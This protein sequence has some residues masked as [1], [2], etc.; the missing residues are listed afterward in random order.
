MNSAKLKLPLEFPEE[1]KSLKD[2]FIPLGNV[3]SHSYH[4][5]LY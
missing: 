3:M 2:R 1:G 4:L 5:C